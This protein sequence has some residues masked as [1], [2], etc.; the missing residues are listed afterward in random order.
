[1]VQGI[2][3]D[4]TLFMDGA[5]AARQAS[6]RPGQ[7]TAGKRAG[8]QAEKSAIRLPRQSTTVPKTS[9]STAFTAGIGPLP[10]KRCRFGLLANAGGHG[11]G[12][13]G[14]SDGSGGKTGQDEQTNQ[15]FDGHDHSHLSLTYVCLSPKG[16]VVKKRRPS[17]ADIR[18]YGQANAVVEQKSRQLS[19]D[20]AKMASAH[21]RAC[22]TRQIER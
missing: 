5:Y 1:L 8:D 11:Y 17:E 2:S 10:A 7:S 13:A 9:K 21:A 19:G 18:G 16:V 15:C 3:P 12:T 4:R 14:A 6:T 20:D 22:A